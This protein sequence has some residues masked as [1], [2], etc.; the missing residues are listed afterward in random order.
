[1]NGFNAPMLSRGRLVGRPRF[2]IVVSLLTGLLIS[3]LAT[4][5]VAQTAVPGAVAAAQST[6][7]DKRSAPDATDKSPHDRQADLRA[8]DRVLTLLKDKRARTELVNDIER[9]RSGAATTDDAGKGN[10]ASDNGKKTSG[11]GKAEDGLL[12]AVTHAVKTA[13]GKAPEALAAPL[14]RKVDEAASEMQDQLEAAL[15]QGVIQ[16][17]TLQ[18]APGW[19]LALVLAFG[20]NASPIVRR[21]KSKLAE[22]V[23]AKAENGEIIR[24]VLSR[25]MWGC[26]P[27]ACG[28]AIIGGWP[29]VLGMDDEWARLF[30]LFAIPVLVAGAVWQLTRGLLALL[31]PSRGWRRSVYA[32]RR[33]VPWLAG[34]AAAAAASAI[35][36]SSYIWDVLSASVA[37]LAAIVLDLGIGCAT[38]V[39]IF[40][41]RLLVRS[42]MIRRHKPST[43]PKQVSPLWRG[44]SILAKH[45]HIVGIVFVLAHMLARLLGGDVDFVLSSILSLV[46]IVVGLMVALSIDASLAYRVKKQK[47]FADNVIRRVRARYLQIVR[48]FAQVFI[49]VLIGLIGFKIW[50]LDVEASLDSRTGWSILRP[51]LS[52]LAALTF[53]W[54]LWIAL[55]SFIE[56]ALSTVDRHGRE[57]A[58]SSRTKTLLPLIRNLVFVVLCAVIVVAVLANLGINV[59]PLLAGAG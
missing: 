40:R 43:A 25:A 6:P 54:M 4:G 26:L 53:G 42:L 24:A 19:L 8:L 23:R 3:A 22:A 44:Y 14:D 11:K 39:F 41:Y 2:P 35:L 36:R 18:S 55:D 37:D 50:G 34:L 47:R 16:S 32:Q 28:A 38:L 9:L 52:I 48:V 21:G 12:G 58:Q 49:V 27:L 29:F 31:G 7:Q 59:A 51:V 45:W 20:L 46:A 30:Y 56:N 1:M 17:F 33:I 13:G 15:R 10:A 57:R 5:A